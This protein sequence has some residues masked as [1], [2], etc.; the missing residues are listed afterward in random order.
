[1]PL[2][3]S[4]AASHTIEQIAGE[5]GEQARWYQLYWPRDR[6]LARSFVKRAEQAGY[7]GLHIGQPARV[8]FGPLRL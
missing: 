4:S 1:V 5:L 2:V 3:A 6:E 7:G 8:L